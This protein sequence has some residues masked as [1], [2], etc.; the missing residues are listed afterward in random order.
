LTSVIITVIVTIMME[1][2]VTEG[3]GISRRVL[4]LLAGLF[5]AGA[6][7]VDVP[8]PETGP[9]SAIVEWWWQRARERK[10]R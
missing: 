8:T 2:T 7:P 9:G 6:V 4:G 10:M 3:R 1:Q 5:G